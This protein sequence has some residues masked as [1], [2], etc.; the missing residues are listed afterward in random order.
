MDFNTAATDSLAIVEIRKIGKL[1]GDPGQFYHYSNWNNFLQ[2]KIVE[3]VTGEE[4]RKY[5]RMKYF[6]PLK[7]WGALYAESPPP[8]V[9]H[10]TRSYTEHYGDDATSLPGYKNFNINFA[11]LYLSADD[12]SKWLQFVRMKYDQTNEHCRHFYQ[13]SSIDQ[14]GPLGILEYHH[15]NLVHHKHGGQAYSAETLIDKDY[16]DDLT[17]VLLT[18]AREPGQLDSLRNRFLRIL[19]RGSA[20]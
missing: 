6:I 9:V 7:M 8:D 13:Q 5:I 20:Q 12:I 17:I 3:A 14:L 11:H 15:G 2:A 4:F 18:N 10:I 1:H 16:S 19:K